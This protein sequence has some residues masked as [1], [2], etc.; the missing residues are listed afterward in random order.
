MRRKARKKKARCQSIHAKRRANERFGINLNSEQLV[1]EIQDQKLTF[2]TRQ[3]NRVTLWRKKEDDLDI[4][5]VYDSNTKEIV[6]VMPYEWYLRNGGIDVSPKEEE[7]EIPTLRE[8]SVKRFHPSYK[9][10]WLNG[11]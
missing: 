1:K 9:D 5:V 10:N 4:V 3:S 6:T 2:L 11:C 7:Q 8:Q